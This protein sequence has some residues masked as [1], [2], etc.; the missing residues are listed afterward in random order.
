MSPK[1]R[2]P[3]PGYAPREDV[4][5]PHPWAFL[6]AWRSKSG[7][8][9][10]DVADALQTSL[11]RVHRWEKGLTRLPVTE[12]IR[13]AE[14]F[15]A[16]HPSDLSWPPDA[17]AQDPAVKEVT[18][19]AGRMTSDALRDWVALGRRLAE[20]VSAEEEKKPPRRR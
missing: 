11:P 10:Q 19:L 2:K 16:A 9:L 18:D 1:R 7:R 15:G 6:G 12:L 5:A 20:P 14:L 3:R 4:E 17:T 13:L 8:T